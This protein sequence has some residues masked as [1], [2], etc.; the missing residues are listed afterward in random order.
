MIFSY[1]FVLER[2]LLMMA[3]G[4]VATGCNSTSMTS[5][6]GRNQ[7]LPLHRQSANESE[8]LRTTTLKKKNANSRPDDDESDL[9]T[10]SQALGKKNDH[11]LGRKGTN[12]ICL[13]KAIELRILFLIDST[14]SMQDSVDLIKTNVR[15]FSDALEDISFDSETVKVDKVSIGA[16]SYRDHQ[17][18]TKK[19]P[20]GPAEDVGKVL[21]GVV[22]GDGGDEYEGGLHALVDAM[23]M[24]KENPVDKDHELVPVVI[25]ITDTFSHNGNGGLQAG[26]PPAPVQMIPRDCR[27]DWQLLSERLGHSTFDK[28]V[29]YDASPFAANN[30]GLNRPPPCQGYESR[31]ASPASQWKDIRKA[32]QSVGKNRKAPL[33]GKGFGFPFTSQGLIETL[34]KDIESS[35]ES[36]TN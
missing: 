10:K 18:E 9:D 15:G 21:E 7:Q 3:A 2:I 14:G 1:R 4:I 33:I 22:I 27:I 13:S 8:D 28:M 34:P 30:I 35:F 6:A 36:C 31:D 16:I 12:T 11:D 29:L 19:I 25:A 17:S 24:L 23:D 5:S 32:W 26:P 20:L